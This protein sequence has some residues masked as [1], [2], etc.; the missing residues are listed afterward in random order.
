[1]LSIYSSNCDLDSEKKCTLCKFVDDTKLVCVS[2]MPEG[3]ALW[4]REGPHP[5]GPRQA[6]ETIWKEPHG[7]QHREM[8]KPAS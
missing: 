1:M 4:G 6:G 5:E 7:V 3:H 8:T 2:D